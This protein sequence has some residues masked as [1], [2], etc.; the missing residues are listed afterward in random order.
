MLSSI[1]IKFP[2]NKKNVVET[3]CKCFVYVAGTFY[4]NV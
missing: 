1:L 4:F 3:L 2:A